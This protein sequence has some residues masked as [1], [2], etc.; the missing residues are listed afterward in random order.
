MFCG[1]I[2]DGASETYNQFF[3]PYEPIVKFKCVR[4]QTY[5]YIYLY[6]DENILFFTS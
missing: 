1:V 3:L 2:E 6:I 4:E 5:M